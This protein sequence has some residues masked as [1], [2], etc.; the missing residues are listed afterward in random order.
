MT[1][2]PLLGMDMKSITKLNSTQASIFSRRRNSPCINLLFT[3]EISEENTAASPWTTNCVFQSKKKVLRLKI[4]AAPVS[5]CVLI[6]SSISTLCLFTI[7]GKFIHLFTNGALCT[8]LEHI[9][10]LIENTEKPHMLFRHGCLLKGK[11]NEIA[12][13]RPNHAPPHNE[14]AQC[15]NSSGRDTLCL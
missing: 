8:F 3:N 2:I 11:K 7:W 13:P 9:H 10:S 6:S 4:T 14:V 12:E 15:W 1:C 5:T